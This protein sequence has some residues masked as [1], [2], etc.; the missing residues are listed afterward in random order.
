MPYEQILWNH[1]VELNDYIVLAATVGMA[2][3][4]YATTINATAAWAILKHDFRTKT[5]LFAM[6]FVITNCISICACIGSIV[7]FVYAHITITHELSELVAFA[8]GKLSGPN[9]PKLLPIRSMFPVIS[10]C[11][12]AALIG[13]VFM[14]INV[15]WLVGMWRGEFVEKEN[16]HHFRAFVE[17]NCPR[18][19]LVKIKAIVTWAKKRFLPPKPSGI[20]LPDTNESC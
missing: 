2:W 20:I 4:T 12:I 5:N 19:V 11:S 17:H 6:L 13:V 10:F 15:L 8:Q 18:K 3:F 7:L 1:I 9:P 14:F 16:S